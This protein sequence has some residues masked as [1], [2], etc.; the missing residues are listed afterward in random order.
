MNVWTFTVDGT[1]WGYRQGRKAAFLPDRVSFKKMV[2]LLANI[3]GVPGRALEEDNL[4]LDVRIH[5]KRKA[6][7][8]GPNVYKLIE[9]ALWTQDRGV[10]G[11]LW[12]R[13]TFQP[14]EEA[15]VTIMQPVYIATASLPHRR[16]VV[17][18]TGE[19]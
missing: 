8:D 7:I 4:F 16:E 5:W 17:I 12:H 13:N 14:R 11:G 9:D 18:G 6:R 10:A 1:L 19:A 2:R 3:E 15:I